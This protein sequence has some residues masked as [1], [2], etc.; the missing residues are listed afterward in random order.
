MQRYKKVNRYYKNR[1]LV[2][3]EYFTA[4]SFISEEFIWDRDR[5]EEGVFTLKSCKMNM[6]ILA[7]IASVQSIGKSYLR[8]VNLGAC[9]ILEII[10]SI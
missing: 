9:H 10:K 5:W 8:T 4:L 3:E 1:E 6:I 7:C 2:G